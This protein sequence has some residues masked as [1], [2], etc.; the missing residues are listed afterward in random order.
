MRNEIENLERFKL[1]GNETPLINGDNVLKII[2]KYKTESE[3]V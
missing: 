2:D 3:V 1:R